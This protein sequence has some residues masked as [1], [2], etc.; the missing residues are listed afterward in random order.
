MALNPRQD[1]KIRLLSQW[2]AGRVL[3]PTGQVM[4]AH[5]IAVPTPKGFMRLSDMHDFLASIGMPPAFKL[6]VTRYIAAHYPKTSALLYAGAPKS[7]IKSVF[8]KEKA[9]PYA[10]DRKVR[11]LQRQE[12]TRRKTIHRLSLR[13][14]SKGADRNTVK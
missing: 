13:S 6:S 8:L 4:H 7:A 9:T 2:P 5:K 12:G 14:L 1:L 11:N 3:E 10:E